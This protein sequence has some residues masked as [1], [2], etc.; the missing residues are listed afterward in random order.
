[1][2]KQWYVIC[3]EDRNP[4]GS[5]GRLYIKNQPFDSAADAHAYARTIDKSREPK[6]LIPEEWCGS[7]IS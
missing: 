6:V 1:M 7:I 5:P 2:R 3:R 4:D